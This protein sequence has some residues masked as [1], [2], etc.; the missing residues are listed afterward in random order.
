[1]SFDLSLYAR[2]GGPPLE[3]S[4]FFAYFTEDKLYAPDGDSVRYSNRDTGVYFRLTWYD[5]DGE[6]PGVKEGEQ[7]AR[8]HIHFNMNFFRPHTF[9][10]EAVRV[11]ER[12][13]RRFDLTVYDPQSDGMG[14]GDFSE[15]GFLRSWNSGNRFAASAMGQLRV[16][17][18]NLTLPAALNEAYW[19]WNYCR[20]MIGDDFASLDLIDVY[21]PPIWFCR[22]NGQA[23]SFTLFPDLVPTAVPKV[24]YVLILRNELAAP[25]AEHSNDTPAWV[26]WEELVAAAPGFEV[27]AAEPEDEDHPHLILYHVDDY[28][29]KD[30][31]PESLARWVIGL[32]DWPGR[33]DQVTPDDILDAELLASS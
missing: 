4:A 20:T 13:V 18:P 6:A 11:L 23:K 8:P 9:G 22:E 10:L 26:R 14:E 15:E 1:M 16:G 30:K 7:G 3:R 33:P 5:G 24:D 17:T 27:R 2:E 32:P 31:V 12:L 28:P 25:Y 21:V 19:Q 29:N